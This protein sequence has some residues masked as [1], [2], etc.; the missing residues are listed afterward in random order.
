MQNPK[1]EV[2]EYPLIDKSG[3]ASVITYASSAYVVSLSNHLMYGLRDHYVALLRF[4]GVRNHKVV[5]LTV[6]ESFLR[7]GPQYFWFKMKEEDVNEVGRS[8]DNQLEINSQ[9]EEE[10][11]LMGGVD[12]SYTSALRFLHRIQQ[13]YG[14]RQG[15]S[16][17]L[18]PENA[19]KTSFINW[20]V[21]EKEA[22]C[23]RALVD[24]RAAY[25]AGLLQSKF[26]PKLMKDERKEWFKTCS[27]REATSGI[28]WKKLAHETEGPLP[29]IFSCDP[30]FHNI[31]KVS[32]FEPDYDRNIPQSE[33]EQVIKLTRNQYN[34]EIGLLY[35]QRTSERRM[36][37]QH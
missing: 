9:V 5:A 25:D 35:M 6:L 16:L 4:L 22:R 15:K 20:W 14:E 8:H 17:P 23:N 10:I 7:N 33:A 2:C 13:R 18:V 28:F 21:T 32:K 37:Q 3:M 30:G 11:M 19:M 27:F 36:Q 1:S 34:N 24:K 26:K 31:W 12:T 29:R